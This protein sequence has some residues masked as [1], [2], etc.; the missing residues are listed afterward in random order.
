MHFFCFVFL[1]T[2]HYIL[3]L[4]NTRTSTSNQEYVFVSKHNPLLNLA[5]L[6]IINNVR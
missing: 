4:S 5:I 2:F 1:H 3:S 6:P